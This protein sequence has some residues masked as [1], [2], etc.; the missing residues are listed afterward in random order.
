VE[1]GL[2]NLAKHVENIRIFGESPVVA[3]NRF[4]AD[5]EMAVV[6]KWCEA[7]G[8]PFALS[9][10]FAKGGE[11]GVALAETVAAHAEKR[12]KPFTPLYDW[13]EPIL[14]KM[15]KVARAT[16][17]AQEVTWTKEAQRA[18][19]P[20]GAHGPGGWRSGAGARRA[21]I[22]HF[23]ARVLLQLVGPVRELRA[24]HK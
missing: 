17:G 12:S 8:V 20:G 24:V 16:Y 21:G 3:L 4:G 18:L 23:G 1:R 22:N 6:R 10:V 5:N 9:D 19:A 13:N 7:A 2:G 14:V 15:E 11:G